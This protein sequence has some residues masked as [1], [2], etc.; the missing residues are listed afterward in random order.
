LQDG[1][2]IYIVLEYCSGGDL[3]HFI[4]KYKKVPEDTARNF[5]QQLSEGLKEL[6]VHN[7]VHVRTTQPSRGSACDQSIIRTG[8]FIAERTKA[9][10][11]DGDSI[12]A[13]PLRS[14]SAVFSEDAAHTCTLVWRAW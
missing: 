7:V 12:H 11:L 3:G 8:T 4:K 6:R 10:S 1:K 2:K 5:M 13:V 9:L 14:L